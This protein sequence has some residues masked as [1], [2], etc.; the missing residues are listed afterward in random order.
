MARRQIDVYLIFSGVNQDKLLELFNNSDLNSNF[1]EFINLY[2]MATSEKYS[3]FYVDASNCKYR[4]NFNR[5][6]V[7]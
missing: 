4:V 5:E 6:I 2:K 1:D 3:F 7:V